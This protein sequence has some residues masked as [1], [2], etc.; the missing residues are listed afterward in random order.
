M[1]SH[2]RHQARCYRPADA[3]RSTFPLLQ[4][5][6]SMT[7]S[8]AIENVKASPIQVFRER[9]EARAMLVANGHMPLIEAV[10]GLQESAAQGL[11]KRYGQDE[12]QWIMAV[13]FARWWSV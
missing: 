10:D 2:H 8:A 7:A 11:L 3:G 5:G 4:R 12:L 1:G 6:H 9:Y 13:S